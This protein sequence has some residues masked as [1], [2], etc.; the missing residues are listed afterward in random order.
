MSTVHEYEGP[1][2]TKSKFADKNANLSSEC[3]QWLVILG[4]FSRDA[5]EACEAR[6]IGT[7]YSE[8]LWGSKFEVKTVGK[9]IGNTI[10]VRENAVMEMPKKFTYSIL[11]LNLFLFTLRSCTVVLIQKILKKLT[12]RLTDFSAVCP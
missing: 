5:L 9:P 2:N 7:F 8:G 11:Q 12:F 3:A 1:A 10:I 6:Y 4:Y